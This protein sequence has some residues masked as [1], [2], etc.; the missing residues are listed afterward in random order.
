MKKLCSA[1]GGSGEI[2]DTPY[3]GYWAWD[4]DMAIE[5]ESACPQCDG[6]GFEPCDACGNAGEVYSHF[7]I[8]GESEKAVLTPCEECNS[9]GDRELTP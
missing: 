5:A 1:C 7:A 8:E 3:Y 4:D 2:G 6:D 9:T